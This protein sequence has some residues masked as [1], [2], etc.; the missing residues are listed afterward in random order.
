MSTQQKSYK[1]NRNMFKNRKEHGFTLVEILVVISIIAVIGTVVAT[2]I[3]NATQSN[4]KFSASNMTQSELLDSV[5]RVTTQVSISSQILIA[6]STKLRMKTTEDGI[7]YETTYFYWANDGD[8]NNIP[9]GVDK[10][11]LPNQ[12]AFLE[13]KINKATNNVVVTNL[14][15]NYV[16]ESGAKPIFTYFTTE[17]ELIISPVQE[18][19]LSSIKRVAVYFAITPS[20]REAEM[21]IATSAVPRMA[22]T[23]AGKGT[24]AAVPIPQSTVL[25]GTLPPGTRTANLKWISVAGA[26]QYNIYRDGA[27]H[28]PVGPNTTTL[29][30]ANLNWGQTYL[31]HAIVTG[32]AGQSATSNTV[33]LT[34]VPDKPKFVNKNTLAG[35]TTV[36][37]GT[38]MAGTT[39]PLTGAKYS[40]ARGLTNQLAWTPMSG[41]TGYRVTD[42]AGAVLYTGTAT[43]VQFP[44]NYG[45]VKTYYVYAF[46]VGQNGSGGDS[47]RSDPIT[48]ISPPRAP[49]IDTTAHDNTAI[50]ADSSNTV[51]I[52]TVPANTK[53]YIY[54]SGSST[55][56]SNTSE[57]TRGTGTTANQRVAW[58][59]TTWYGAI[60]YN[61]AG[62]SPESATVSALQKPGPFAITDLTQ[63]QRAVYTNKLEWDGVASSNA[64]GSVRADWGDSAGRADYDIVVGIHDSL[65]GS[66][67]SNTSWRTGTT[68]N[69]YSSTTTMTPGAIYL[70]AVKATAP[71]GLTRDATTRYFQTAPDVPRNGEVWIVCRNLSNGQ[72]YNHV[73]TSDTRPLYGGTDRTKQ[74]QF[75]NNGGGSGLDKDLTPGRNTQQT[76]SDGYY[77]GYTSGFIL[78]NELDARAIAWKAS[79]LSHQIKA[80]GG[81]KAASQVHDDFYG[82]SSTGWGEP[83]DPCYGTPTWYAGCGLGAGHPR[84]D[85]S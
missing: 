76:N 71:N 46:N 4:Q 26:T 9:P 49:V 30:D 78:Q 6:D 84:W 2:L 12:K 38:P 59:S 69:S 68:T 11:K 45:D 66:V 39:E 31:Y 23:S 47:V 42:A 16:R 50:V 17:D 74:T 40:V 33:S 37:S 62:N 28:Q 54:E 20:G 44:T 58:G 72:H 27:L 13:Y 81:Y 32:Y 60:A 55:G 14:I 82:C 29:A 53:G 15:S 48:L 75:S 5:A 18:A 41:A 80:Y 24:G 83:D 67:V 64:P 1:L 21:E 65:G 57:F 51:T 77:H 7:E 3:I 61:D 79:T 35:L 70:Y 19:K 10:T 85:A 34:V 63:T 8:A 25:S 56:S 52:T 43:N 73:Y 36:N 22:I